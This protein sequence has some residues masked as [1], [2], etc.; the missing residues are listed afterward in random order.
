MARVPVCAADDLSPGRPAC[1]AHEKERIAVF[2]IGGALYACDDACPHA[3]GPLHMGFLQG[4]TVSCPWHGWTFDLAE[5]NG[6][7]GGVR[8]YPVSVVD[9]MVYIE[10][11]ETTQEGAR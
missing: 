5:T 9:G 4:A 6:P 2:N 1:V 3:G 10:M 7:S 11:P 8:R